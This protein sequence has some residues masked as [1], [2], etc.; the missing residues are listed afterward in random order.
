MIW[1][2]LPTTALAPPTAVRYYRLG[3]ILE[4]GDE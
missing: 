4:D 2:T 3:D 1:R